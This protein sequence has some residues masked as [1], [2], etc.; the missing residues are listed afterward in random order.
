MYEEKKFVRRKINWLK[1]LVKLLLLF[2]IIFLIWY[3]VQRIKGRKKDEKLNGSIMSENLNYLKDKYLK[4]YSNEDLPKYVN[5]T[6]TITLKVLNDKKI[7]KTI[8]DRNGKKCNESSSYGKLTNTGND[9]Y[10]LKV[11]LKCK[12]EADSLIVKLTKDDIVNVNTNAG[13]NNSSSNNNSNTNKNNNKNNNSN[14]NNKN[15]N[16]SN[17]NNN[18][19]NNKTN[20]NTTNTNT[21]TTNKNNQTTTNNKQNVTTNNSSNT[22]SSSTTTTTKTTTSQTTTSTQ[23]NSSSSSQSVIGKV[24]NNNNNGNSS[25]GTA[26]PNLD[27]PVVTEYLM[28]KLGDVLETEPTGQKYVSFKVKVDYYKYCVGN[29]IYNCHKNF[30][31]IPENEKAIADLLSYGY[32]E[33]YD[34]TDTVTMYQVVLDEVWNKTDKLDGYIYTGKSRT[35]YSVN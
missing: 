3:L 6:S 14:S 2:L 20:N 9:T 12:N 13:K 32:T 18:N 33:Y 15:N 22:S 26:T 28:Y 7:S 10:D 30:A 25:S 35:H 34:Y 24:D 19:N 27:K 5:E 31:K 4:Y 16:T 11:Y 21:N 29:D 8:K 23:T 17:T 1:V